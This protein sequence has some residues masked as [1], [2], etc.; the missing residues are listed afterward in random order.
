MHPKRLVVVGLALVAVALTWTP[1]AHA[2]ANITGSIRGSVT[3]DAG[4]FLPGATIEVAGAPLGD[5]NRTAITNAE[6]IFVLNGLPVGVYSMT[7]SLIGYRPYEV[8]Q[9]VVN[10]DETR[11]FN[12]LKL[13]EGLSEKITVQAERPVVDTSNTSSKEVLDATYVNKLPLISRRYQQIL[14][15]FPGVNN[16]QGFTLA[17]YHINGSRVTQN[18]FRLDGATVNDFVTG[19]FGLNVNQNSIERFEVNTSGFQPEYGEQSGGIANIITKSGTNSFELL[20][21]GFARTENWSSGVDGFDELEASSDADFDRENNHNPRPETQQWQELSF[22]GPL[23]KNKLWFASSF[24]YWQEDIGSVFSDSVREG[25]RYHGQFKVTWQVSP[26][27][28]FVANF[29]TDPSF[30]KNLI[31]DARYDERTNFDQNQGAYFI[32][33]RDTHTLSPNA[34]LETQLFAHHQYLTVR[35]TDENAGMFTG[36][37]Q[38]GQPLTFSGSYF[39]DQDRSTDRIRLS[40]ALTVQKG[41]HRIKTGLDYS[42]LDFTG[43]NRVEPFTLNLDE[44]LTAYYAYAPGSTYRIVYD[45]RNPEVTDRKDAEAAAFIQDTWVIN[46][47]WTVEGGVRWDHQT[48]IDQQNVAPRL[49]VAYDPQGK[50]KTKFFGNYGRFYDNV[51]ADITDFLNTDG[52]TTTITLYNAGTSSTTSATYVY[53]YA[54]DGDLET[55]YKDSW[56]VGVEQELPWNV[57]VGLSTTRWEGNNQLRTTFTQDLGLVPSSVDLDPNAT[58]AVIL[59]SKGESD[60]A[61]WKLMVRKPFSHR[62]E[63]IGSYTR[64]RV[65]GDSSVDFGFENRGDPRALDFTRLDYDRPDVINLSAFGNLPLGLEVTGI[66][67]YQSGRLYSP[68]DAFND[69]D[70]TVGGKNSER[71]PPVR[72]LDLSLAKRF[73]VGRAQLRLTG[74]VF[75]L[76]NQLNVV[77][78]ERLSGASTFRGPVEVD[79]G[80]IVQLGLEVRY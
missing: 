55:P 14:T 1:P 4:N 37:F 64:S 46:E 54:I 17:Q 24:Q 56:T 31:T 16:D 40:S 7:I 78:V 66:Y 80:R 22:S 42:F 50:G 23:I 30:F 67:R 58:A 19:T 26:D 63:V 53:D 32:Q 6:G 77:D 3:D 70:T 33:L 27:N 35:P 47:H 9:I 8:V 79:F 15:L 45:Y 41:T 76:T 48:A 21:S 73:Q 69:I 74:Q 34:F 62:F 72:S 10:P 39:N 18:G 38:A 75:N 44:L 25:D 49:G 61:D 52:S 20:Y 60:Y 71:M 36:L 51:F 5:S 68:V 2:Q 12:N 28:T 59:D 13:P 29:A 11:V 65:R 57:R 43:T